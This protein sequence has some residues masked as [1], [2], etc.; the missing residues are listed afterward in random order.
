[1]EPLPLLAGDGKDAA[2]FSSSFWSFQDDL[3][4]HHQPQEVL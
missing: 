1:M 4:H 2:L 3:L